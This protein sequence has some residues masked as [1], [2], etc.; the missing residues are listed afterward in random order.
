MEIMNRNSFTLLSKA[1]LSVGLF[2]RNSCLLDNFCQTT[3]ILHFTK[4]RRK[5]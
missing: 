2:S 5:V 3:S 4:N 1:S